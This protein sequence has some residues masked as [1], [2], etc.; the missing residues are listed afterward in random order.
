MGKYIFVTHCTF[1]LFISFRGWCPPNAALWYSSPAPGMEWNSAEKWRFQWGQVLIS[2]Y[3][4]LGQWD[5]GLLFRK[6]LKNLQTINFRCSGGNWGG[7]W[8][9]TD[10]EEKREQKETWQTSAHSASGKGWQ[11]FE[12]VKDPL[13]IQNWIYQPWRHGFYWKFLVL[14]SLYKD[15]HLIP[16]HTYSSILI[17]HDENLLASG[18]NYSI[19]VFAILHK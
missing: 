13:L 12:L 14:I 5:E 4:Q 2:R 6:L 11:I 19:H 1:N 8:G 9:G 10:G 15:I 17:L 3:L 18:Y 7:Y 16:P